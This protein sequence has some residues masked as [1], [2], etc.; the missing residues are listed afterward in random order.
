MA[1]TPAAVESSMAL[2]PCENPAGRTL[3]AAGERQQQGFDGNHRQAG[4]FFS[5]HIV[6]KG[7]IRAS[8][9]YLCPARVCCIAQSAIS[10]KAH[11]YCDLWAEI[12][13]RLFHSNKYFALHNI[14]CVGAEWQLCDVNPLPNAFKA[15]V[16]NILSISSV[17]VCYP[18]ARSPASCR[19]NNR[20]G[21]LNL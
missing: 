9:I 2:Y 3:M 6:F 14:M 17:V 12:G 13:A 18:T 8:L 7:R 20:P 21:G 1:K 16:A 10:F 11:K 4:A 15:F 19:Q 5:G